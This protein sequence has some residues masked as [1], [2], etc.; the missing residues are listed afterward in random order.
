MAT[1]FTDN[2]T[3]QA[4]AIR[5][6][7]EGDDV[8]PVTRDVLMGALATVEA[9]KRQRDRKKADAETNILAL[10]DNAT[11]SEIRHARQRQSVRH[12]AEVYLPSWQQGTFA[13]PNSLIRSGLFAAA[14]TLIETTD[15]RKVG[16]QGATAIKLAG[17]LLGYDSHVF[18]ALLILAK[19]SPLAEAHSPWI[20]VSYW[21]FSQAMS[22]PYG[23]RVQ[24]AIKKSL[25]RLNS[26]RVRIRVN[27]LDIKLSQLIEV[28]FKAVPKRK[29]SKASET[30]EPTDGEEIAF[31]IPQ[32]VAELFGWAAW[33]KVP[34]AAL[35]RYSGLV[36]WLAT[37]YSS[38][39]KSYPVAIEDMHGF[40][41]STC[42]VTEFKRRL[43]VSLKKLQTVDTPDELRV[44]DFVF[45]PVEG[46]MTITVYLSRWNEQ[47]TMSPEEQEFNELD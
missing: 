27:R 23:V 17:C 25:V 2:L 40:T 14:E 46:V 6:L 34:A 9:V 1:I 22:V 18:A 15:E 32:P 26:A 36:R 39:A 11:T 12:G 30:K 42:D 28:E 4:N 5:R 43:K 7:A 10:P 41:G 21:Q 45:G 33:T 31:R 47:K 16:T 13:L 19:D 20:Q 37:Y 8:H 44:E 24:A 35:T 29:S 38:H 3:A